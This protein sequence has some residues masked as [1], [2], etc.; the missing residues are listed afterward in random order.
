MT[1]ERIIKQ[2]RGII[3]RNSQCPY[4]CVLYTPDQEFIVKERNKPARSSNED[5]C[6][7]I[8]GQYP[9][10]KTEV[11]TIQQEIWD[12]DKKDFVRIAEP[13]LPEL[14][15]NRCIFIDLDGPHRVL[16]YIQAIGKD[17]KIV[18]IK[19]PKLD[20]PGIFYINV[21]KQFPVE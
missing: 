16:P 7:T 3:D 11:F 10:L 15:R 2:L 6:R 14:L 21:S 1:K 8:L 20:A 5:E 18:R 9:D 13:V 17:G 4:T 19:A 12:R